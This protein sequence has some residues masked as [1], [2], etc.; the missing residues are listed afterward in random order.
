MTKKKVL[1]IIETNPYMNKDLSNPLY[2]LFKK[3]NGF[4]VKRHFKHSVLPLILS[5][6]NDDKHDIIIVAVDHYAHQLL[7]ENEID[8][9]TQA[10]YI[11]ESLN[12]DAEEEAIDVVRNMPNLIVNEDFNRA[13]RYDSTN[14][15]FLSE[16]GL[17]YMLKDVIKNIKTIQYIIEI[18]MPDEIF[19]SRTGIVNDIVSA[20]YGAKILY[21]KNDR[22]CTILNKSIVTGTRYALSLV[23]LVR[24]ADIGRFKRV[25][26]VKAT[27]QK[28]ILFGNEQRIG[29]M[30]ISW[31]NELKGRIDTL[32][33]GIKSEWSGIYKDYSIP[34]NLFRGY[35][36]KQMRKEINNK[37]KE[38]KK[39]WNGLIKD[40]DFK[41]SWKYEDVNLWR[42][43]E[44]GLTYY[45]LYRFI[46]IIRYGEITKEVIHT[47]KPDVVVTIDDRSPFG[48]TVNVI[49]K[50]LGVPTLMVQ[51][52]IVADHP[53][54][55]PICSDKMAVFGHAFKDA[56]VKRGVNPDDIVV[57]GQPRFDVLVNTKYDKK[58]I[59]E[60][61]NLNGE[62]GLI[63][64]ASTDLPD[65]EK[66]LTVRELCAAM[67]QFPDKQLVI[68]PHP[69]D[70]GAMF[71]DL[72]CKFNLDAIVVHDYLYELLSACDL[73]ITTWSTVGLEAMILDKPIIVI[74]L[75]N[76]PDMTSYVERGAAIE[77]NMPNALSGIIGQ[78]LYD[79]DTIQRIKEGRNKYILDYTYRSDG[80]A[81]ERVAKL[82]EMM[83]GSNQI[84]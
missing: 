23:T 68:K 15:W 41:N 6:I 21:Y 75:M 58:W 48:K 67:K 53:I 39:I 82:I 14:L 57:T 73:L 47:E 69:S 77:V 52:G 56:L 43:L 34:Y 11:F 37:R 51:H 13:V 59:Y 49:S 5:N 3:T 28:V 61:L 46:D 71:V 22:S 72:L 2:T 1:M 29:N 9:K 64:F 66:E 76:R 84:N 7:Y 33:L 8:H 26:Q 55:G 62:K 44:L 16:L 18:E 38:L 70:D 20:D 74:N 27:R 35:E 54:Y 24:H 80:K 12:S 81:S 40:E 10:D 25:S 45:F 31:L 50:S 65:D 4:F 79:G 42:S 36:S 60:K 17:W 32:A 78:I 19:A 30:S 83:V 63:V